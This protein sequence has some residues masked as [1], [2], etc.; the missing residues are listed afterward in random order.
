MVNSAHMPFDALNSA[1]KAAGEAS[2]RR[3]AVNGRAVRVTSEPNVEIVAAPQRLTKLEFRQS[4][5]R[6][7]R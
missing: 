5:P 3:M 4:P 7:S 2:S 6:G 1:L